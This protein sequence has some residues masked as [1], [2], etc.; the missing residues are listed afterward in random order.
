MT[1]QKTINRVNVIPIKNPT[2]FC[3]DAQRKYSPSNGKTKGPGELKQSCTI[4]EL[5]EV[6]PF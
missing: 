1:L 3:T 5:P 6:S 2:Q 4:N